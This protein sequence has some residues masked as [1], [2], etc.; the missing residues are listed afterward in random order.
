MDRR[1]AFHINIVSE[2]MG[3]MTNMV[4]EVHDAVFEEEEEDEEAKT[5][6]NRSFFKRRGGSP[7]AFNNRTEVKKR[8][9]LDRLVK[10]LK[11]IAGT[12]FNV[13]MIC[14]KPL[15]D[16]IGIYISCSSSG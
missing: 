16:K 4:K 6:A 2:N 12:I 14:S 3:K 10:D 1:L 11:P 9:K 13:S 5:R 8:S 15:F 7:V